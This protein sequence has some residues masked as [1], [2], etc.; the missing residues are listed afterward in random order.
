MKELKKKIK[1]N[2][3]DDLTQ[4][5]ILSGVIAIVVWLIFGIINPNINLQSQ[6]DS[7]PHRYCY[8]ETTFKNLVINGSLADYRN[9]YCSSDV[10]Y[11]NE[12]GIYEINQ[13]EVCEIK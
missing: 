5:S 8:N 12:S 13:K 1:F 2:D 11:V 6:I 4:F 9:Y 3:L 7:L 10:L